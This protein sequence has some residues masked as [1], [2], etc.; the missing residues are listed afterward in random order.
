MAAN[1]LELQHF[2]SV[3]SVKV[4]VLFK[5]KCGPTCHP[6][7]VAAY[8]AFITNNLGLATAQLIAQAFCLF[9]SIRLGNQDNVYL[10][11]IADEY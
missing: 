7:N 3:L 9:C 1:E 6:I 4:P 2:F 5:L 10:V 11:A 8:C